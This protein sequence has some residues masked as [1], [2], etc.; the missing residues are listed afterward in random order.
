MV[1]I[2]L[3]TYGFVARTYLRHK[4]E[5]PRLREEKESPSRQTEKQPESGYG[6]GA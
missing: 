4:E 3:A 5:L 2:G 1:V 6:P